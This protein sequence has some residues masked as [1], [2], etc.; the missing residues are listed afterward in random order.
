MLV[1]LDQE[2]V[3]G[4]KLGWIERATVLHIEHTY[5]HTSPKAIHK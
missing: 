2:G 4:F 3:G 5:F 1:A